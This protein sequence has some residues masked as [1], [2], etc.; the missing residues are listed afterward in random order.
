[1]KSDTVKFVLA[2]RKSRM[3][4][5]GLPA[6]VVINIILGLFCLLCVVPFIFVVIISFS[7]E[8]SIRE[9]GYSFRPIKWSLE[10]YKFAFTSNKGIWRSY[11]N[12]FFITILGTALSVLI[13]V[14]Y[15]Y[16]LFRKDFKYRKFF[17]F[18]CF[19]TMLFGGGL[20][21]TYYVSKN[22]LG[23]ND[24]YAALIV[25]ALFNPFNIIVMRTFFQSSVPTELIEAAAIDGSGEYNTLFKIIVP[26]AKPGIATIALLNAL[27]YW[28]EWY[29]A[30]LYIR[31]EELYPLQYLLMRSQQNIDFL[32]RNATMLGSEIAKIVNDLPQQNLRM[33]LAVLIV[34]PIA[35]A[36]PF[37][38]RFI[39]SGL[40]VGSVKG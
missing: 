26:I 36:Y 6:E 19:F 9:I 40:T 5:I 27:A 12:S 38:Q 13:C 23:L 24:N 10:A 16:P 29:L 15:S 39:I 8:D 17:T 2:K 30:M 22:I 4:S 28:N 1:M 34:V 33:A 32:T 37:F 7:A 21:P 31:T 18:F 25:P 11:F 20:V 3:N 35:F 14:L